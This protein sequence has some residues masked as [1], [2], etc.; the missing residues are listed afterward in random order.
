MPLSLTLPG[1]H[2]RAQVKLKFTRS[3]NDL[4][5]LVKVSKFDVRL[6]GVSWNI[7]LSQM[8]S[9]DRCHQMLKSTSARLQSF[10]LFSIV[11]QLCQSCH[12]VLLPDE[13]GGQCGNQRSALVAALN[14]V[15]ALVAT[16]INVLNRHCRLNVN[17]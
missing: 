9:P 12:L 3:R 4:F 1:P 8:Y 7:D 17:M 16:V 6:L 15:A 10:K 13:S 11:M 2:C 14:L 5:K